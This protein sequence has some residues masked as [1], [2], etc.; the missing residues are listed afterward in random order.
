MS[1][2]CEIFCH[3]WNL[4]KT[5]TFLV[6]RKHCKSEIQFFYWYKIKLICFW[7]CFS[8]ARI[9][10]WK[11][12]VFWLVIAFL[13]KWINFIIECGF[14]VL[15]YIPSRMAIILVWFSHIRHKEK[16]FFKGGVLKEEMAT[17]RWKAALAV[18]SKYHFCGFPKACCGSATC[19]CH[20][21]GH[22]LQAWSAEWMCWKL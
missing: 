21:H 14:L 9:S 17:K 15:S 18:W 20:E 13:P 19:S 5:S 2:R 11:Q 1:E 16:V 10:D 22:L 7:I 4:K 3:F 8:Y 6:H 12:P